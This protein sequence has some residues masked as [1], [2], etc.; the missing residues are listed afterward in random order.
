LLTQI[1]ELNEKAKVI[2]HAELFADVENLYKAG[3]DYVSVPRLV[4]ARELCEV[5]HAVRG[6]LLAQKRADLDAELR[7]RYEVIP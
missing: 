4:E 7:N 3:A 5:I 1:R 6:N 2:V